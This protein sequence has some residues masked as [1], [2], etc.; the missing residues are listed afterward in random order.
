MGM[1]VQWEL[2][3]TT[4]KINKAVGAIFHQPSPFLP[5]F[6]CAVGGMPD[7][8]REM[9]WVKGR[10]RGGGIGGEKKR[11]IDGYMQ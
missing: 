10:E 8:T 1:C 9:E 3:C 5:G 6:L 4:L 2:L 11:G 7:C